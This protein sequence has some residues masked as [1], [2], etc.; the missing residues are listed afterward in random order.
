MDNN[1]KSN[2][3]VD[4]LG[5]IDQTV[6]AYIEREMIEAGEKA[7]DETAVALINLCREYGI[8][9]I[10]LVEFV[11]KLGMIGELTGGKKEIK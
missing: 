6:N 11:H 10:K 4:L 9:G 7:G 1:E 8:R 5:V 3:A 2:P